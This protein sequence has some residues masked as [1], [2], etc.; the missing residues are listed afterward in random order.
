MAFFS[1]LFYLKNTHLIRI[2]TLLFNFENR[3]VPVTHPVIRDKPKLRPV[4]QILHTD[5][6]I[7]I[8]FICLWATYLC[9]TVA[10][11]EPISSCAWQ[12]FSSTFYKGGT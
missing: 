2:S 8:K 7:Q 12:I 9:I 3:Q 11:G 6:L 4:F 10:K 1:L 5:I